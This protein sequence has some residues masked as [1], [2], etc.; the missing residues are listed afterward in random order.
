MY[1]IR[2]LCIAAAVSSFI[3]DVHAA[4]CPTVLRDTPIKRQVHLDTT[5]KNCM[6]LESSQAL[7]S[8]NIVLMPDNPAPYSLHVFHRQGE[9][10]ATVAVY[11]AN[12]DG[13][14]V[15]QILPKGRNLAFVPMLNANEGG[16]KV[17]RLLFTVNKNDGY[18]VLQIDDA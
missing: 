1:C 16:R 6:Y 2:L 3:R 14:L 18:L 11:D 13:M 12:S 17:L 15:A 9:N 7:D 4:E 10:L 8:V 5:V